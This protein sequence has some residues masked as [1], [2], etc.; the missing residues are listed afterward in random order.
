MSRSHRII[1]SLVSACVLVL[2]SVAPAI[3]K[4]SASRRMSGSPEVA[5]CSSLATSA[6]LSVAIV[7]VRP[8]DLEHQLED[9]AVALAVKGLDL[10]PLPGTLLSSPLESRRS[11][12]SSAGAQCWN[13]L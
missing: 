3:A 12:R 7:A 2:V 11:D 8:I 10:Q 9:H 4:R 5:A 1:W 6:I 13:C